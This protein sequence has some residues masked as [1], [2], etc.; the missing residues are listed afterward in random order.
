MTMIASLQCRHVHD[1][2]GRH[3]APDDGGHGY[4][5]VQRAGIPHAGVHAMRHSAATI[6]I[7][8]G[9][10]LAV[11][12]ELLGHSDI[13]VTRDYVDVSSPL[14]RDRAERIGRAL[15]GATRREAKK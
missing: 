1:N 13:R 11:V 8:E 2:A 6:A 5:P 9:V 4:H 12:Q 10:A 7:H 14:A 3:Q 15:F